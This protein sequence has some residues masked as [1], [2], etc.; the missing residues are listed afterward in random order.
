M[1]YKIYRWDS[2]LPDKSQNSL[3]MIYIRADMDLLKFAQ[4]NGYTFDVKISGTDT[5]YDGIEMKGTFDSLVLGPNCLLPAFQ[6]REF[7][8]ICLESYFFEYPRPSKMGTV[9]IIGLKNIKKVRFIEKER[10]VDPILL[11]DDIQ[12]EFTEYLS[13]TIPETLEGSKPNTVPQLIIFSL[14]LIFICVLIFV[15]FKKYK[16][17]K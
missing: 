8:T 5:V 1:R 9:E 14:I 3:P 17:L 7:H 11:K 10:N 15:L 12:E 13:N 16:W 2:I 6:D 4:K